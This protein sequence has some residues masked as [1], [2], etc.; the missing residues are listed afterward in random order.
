MDNYLVIQEKLLE[1]IKEKSEDKLVDVLMNTLH[2][3]LDSAYRRIRLEKILTLDEVI[4]ISNRFNI[5]ID[6]LIS[7]DS[8]DSVLFSFPFKSSQFDLEEY[9]NKILTHLIKV[10]E[11]NGV[12][13][14]SAK[15][16]PI[17]H[18]F[19]D[20]KL[21]AFKLHYWLNS[22]NRTEEIR[23]TEFNY[24]FIPAPIAELTKKIYTVYSQI[25][26]HE[27]WNNETLTRSSSQIT[28]YYEMGILTKTQA[29]E[30]QLRLIDFIKHLNSECEIG[31]KYFIDHE[32][33]STEENYYFYCNEIVSTDNSIYAEYDNIKESFLP[34]ILLNYMTTDNIQYSEYN[35]SVFDTV[36]NKSTL[37]TKVNEK[38]RRKFFNF[39]KQFIEKQI[40]KIEII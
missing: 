36:I 10:K 5:S 37:I 29:N 34:H 18:F 4:K 25:K 27:I 9:F 23:K 13:Y 21:L 30:L 40:N 16:I 12:M 6:H 19:Q 35:K 8:S 24:D 17:F 7:H 3:S 32:P 15:D 38:D 33:Y 26:T 20:K 1:K 14:Y 39:N 28:Y 31:I 2:V 22:M 11:G